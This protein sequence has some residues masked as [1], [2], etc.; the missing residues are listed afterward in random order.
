MAEGKVKT[1]AEYEADL[2]AYRQGRYDAES[3]QAILRAKDPNKP[4]ENQLSVHVSLFY[5]QDAIGT[6]RRQ[7]DQLANELRDLLRESLPDFLAW[8]LPRLAAKESA[9]A[10]ALLSAAQ[11]AVAK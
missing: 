1:L 2:V 10:E 4:S 3:V 11:R 6:N 8:A 5:A 7:V 9:A